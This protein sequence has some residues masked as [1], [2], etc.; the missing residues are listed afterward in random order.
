MLELFKVHHI[1]VNS[2]ADW[3]VIRTPVIIMDFALF[4]TRKDL[5]ADNCIV[6]A[7]SFV[8]LTTFITNIP[9]AVFDFSWVKLTESVTKS[10]VD[11]VGVGL[12]L[13]GSEASHVLISFRIEDINLLMSHIEIADKDDRLTL[14]LQLF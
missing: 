1:G 4:D 5:L 8:L 9:E 7:P 6:E 14:L 2:D 10:H 12:S 11:E 3:A 13:L